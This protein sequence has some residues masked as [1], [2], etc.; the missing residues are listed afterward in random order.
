M[1]SQRTLKTI[2]SIVAVLACSAIGFW[3]L[4]PGDVEP[5]RKEVKRLFLR[6]DYQQAMLIADEALGVQP[7]LTD[8]RLLAAQSSVRLG[9]A[10]KT[11][12]YLGPILKVDFN[13]DSPLKV[14]ALLLQGEVATNGLFDLQQAESAYRAT[15]Q[16]DPDNVKGLEKLIRLLATCGR[17]REAIPFLLQLIQLGYSSDL[18]MII[19]RGSGALNDVDLLKAAHNAHPEDCCALTGLAMHASQSGDLNQAVRFCREAVAVNPEFTSANVY[20]GQYL[21]ESQ[22]FL[23]LATWEKQLPEKCLTFAETWRTLGYVAEHQGKRQLALERF[24]RASQLGPELKDV[25][26]R[27]SQLLNQADAPA[28]AKRFA[29]RLLLIQQLETQQDRMFQSGPEDVP[30]LVETVDAFRMVG[31]VW[32]GYGWTQLGLASR[33]NNK[34]LQALLLELSAETKALPLAMEAP[35][36]NVASKV[37]VSDVLLTDVSP[38][39]LLQTGGNSGSASSDRDEDNIVFSNDAIAAG[40]EFQFIP[41]VVGPTTHR[42][43]EFTGG[44]IGVGD[45]DG[46]DFPD[47]VCTQA[48]L[49]ATRGHASDASDQLFRNVRGSCFDSVATVSGIEDVSFGQGVAVGDIDGDGFPD[50]FVS[51][52]GDNLLWMNNG[53]GTFRRD[54]LPPATVDDEWTTSALIADLNNDGAA[55]VFAANYLTSKDVYD[56]VCISSTGE[57]QSCIPTHFDGVRDVLYLND[58]NGQ[59]VDKSE[60]L[61]SVDLGKGLGVL[62]FSP[63]NDG[64]LQVMVT[65]DTTPNMLLNVQPDGEIMDRGFASGVAV[66]GQG[67][68]EGCM[69]IAVGD[70]DNDGFS[71]LLVTNF[72]NETNTFYHS[73]NGSLYQD[74][75][76]LVNLADSS[77]QQL[78]FGCQLVDADLDGRLELIVANGHVDDLRSTGKPY[79]M[80]TQLFRYQ[81]GGFELSSAD[82]LG[83]YFQQ[84]YLGRSVVCLDWNVDGLPDIAVGH[85][86]QPYALLTN[87]SVDVGSHVSIRFVGLKSSRD[88]IG[89]TVSYQLNGQTITRQLTAGDGYHASNQ[90]E[91]W[92]ACGA[93]DQIKSLSVVWPLGRR[94]AI[95]NLSAGS[96]NILLEGR[97][98]VFQL[99]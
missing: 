41:G 19:S 62:A 88:A 67:K 10:K 36:F 17:R 25:Y 39:N 68:S 42:M 6:G 14:K 46:D 32:E 49:W 29:D 94:Q 89:T 3:L 15:L 7:D 2:L 38:V 82:R 75:T 52:I 69:G 55:D 28:T 44:G 83:P 91:L 57:K 13:G 54:Q 73:I 70:V 34:I 31:R 51:N 74:Q 48:G 26:F 8:T 30:E 16:L 9:D 5:L 60:G 33:R 20:L 56:R 11:L 47:I 96:R 4:S 92:L 23:Q 1:A 90:H 43:F 77:L 93:M 22:Q 35:A 79:E 66:S 50:I 40:F 63:A 85:L 97:N 86:H 71:E 65:N 81:N 95:Q 27:I 99:P 45:F 72:Y 58:Q 98:S 78:G 59:L 18:L 53:D 80:P 24:L 84:Q 12:Q 37:S 64:Q 61:A 87:N 21:L 76:T